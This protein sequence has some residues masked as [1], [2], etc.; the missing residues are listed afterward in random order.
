MT[1]RTSGRVEGTVQGVGFR[2]YVYR[3][4]REEGLVGYVLNDERGVL[5]DVEGA[6]EAIERFVARLPAE[7]PPLAAIESGAISPSH[8]LRISIA[9]V[10]RWS[11]LRSSRS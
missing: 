3:L 8:D 2:P 7:A 9:R 10:S 4:A 1:R 11:C 6:A 5:L